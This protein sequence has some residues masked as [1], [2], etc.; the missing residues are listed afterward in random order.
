MESKNSSTDLGPE[1]HASIETVL[2]GTNVFALSIHMLSQSPEG[3]CQG[4]I[5][6]YDPSTG[7]LT[8]SDVLS[9]EPI[10]LRVP[11][12]TSVVRWG[13]H[14]LSRTLRHQHLLKEH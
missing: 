3:E 5:L 7:E 10:K 1:D 9:R 11:A 6:N 13:K 14:L 4:Q 8:L 12:G 2:D